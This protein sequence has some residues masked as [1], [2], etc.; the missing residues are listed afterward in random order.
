VLDDTPI[1][2]YNK[3]VING[4]TMNINTAVTL[5]TGADM[6]AVRAICAECT[7]RCEASET[8]TACTY[9]RYR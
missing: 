2:A 6:E 4:N 1:T 8:Q 9:A 7:A 5:N 3:P